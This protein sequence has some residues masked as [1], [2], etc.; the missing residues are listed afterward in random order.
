MK[1]SAARSQAPPP[2]VERTP[3]VEFVDDVRGFNRFYTR[4]LGLL[5]RGLLGSKFTLTEAR[6]LYELAHQDGSTATQIADELAMDLGYLSRLMAKFERMRYL[7]RTRSQTDAR[8]SRIHLTDKGRSVFMPLNTAAREQISRM[9][10]PMTPEQRDELLNAMQSVQRLLE[11]SIASPSS[12]PR[13]ASRPATS[14]PVASRPVASSPAAAA[15]PHP[16][17]PPYLLRP[18]QVGD[19]GQITHRQGVL[20][21]QEYGWDVTYEALVAEILGG[22]VKNFDA[23]WENAWIAERDSAVIGS[24]LLVRGSEGVAKLRLL[25][26]EPSARGLG[27]GKR[28]VQECIDDARAKGYRTMT[29]WTN[30]ILVAARR[31]YESAGFRLVKEEPHHSFGKDLVGQTWELEL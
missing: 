7:K 1:S 23:R 18:L 9:I 16:D 24:I 14:R 22:F 13:H 10:Q 5:D 21:S 12:Q 11:P 25:Y 26:V 31:I 3:A 2:T 17:A 29:L 8:Q 6:V 15:S 19:I 28:L 4:Q 20:Y 30:D 27:L